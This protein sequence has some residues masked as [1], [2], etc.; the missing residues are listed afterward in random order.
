M[1]VLDGA[2]L[3]VMR[4]LARSLFC[5]SASFAGA[6]L[7]VAMVRGAGFGAAL[8]RASHTSVSTEQVNETKQS[9]VKRRGALFEAALEVSFY[10]ILDLIF[11]Y[12]RI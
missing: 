8:L 5:L 9:V 7:A 2:V 3:V 11:L 10:L 4:L 1:A 12:I 6:A